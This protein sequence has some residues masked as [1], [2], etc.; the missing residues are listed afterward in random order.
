VGLG[1]D[2]YLSRLAETENPNVTGYLAAR[3][4]ALAQQ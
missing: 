4:E 1:A 3:L 2:K